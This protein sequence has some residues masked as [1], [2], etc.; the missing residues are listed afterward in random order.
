[1]PCEP[2][3]RLIYKISDTSRYI[4]SLDS[5]TIKIRIP[6]ALLSVINLRITILMHITRQTTLGH[7][8]QDALE[9]KGIGF[10]CFKERL[11]SFIG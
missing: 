5:I 11:Q 9:F 6:L 4:D 8:A 7:K 1:M 10:K 2:V 3:I